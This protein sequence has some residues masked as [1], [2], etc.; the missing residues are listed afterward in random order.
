MWR[1]SFVLVGVFFAASMLV[2]TVPVSAWSAVESFE[3]GWG[4]WVPDADVPGV[5]WHITRSTVRAYQG[6]W[7]LEYYLSGIYDQGT[8]WVE[9][10]IP[11]NPFTASQ[12]HIDFWVYSRVK[13]NTNNWAV[14]AYAG[15]ANPE[16]ATDFTIVGQT[17]IGVGWFNYHLDKTVTTSGTSVIWVAFGYSVRWETIRTDYFDYVTVTRTP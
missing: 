14:V 15:A 8:I 10:S 12:V 11:A 4:G 1:R 9:R 16:L 5:P 13:S 6:I 7:S 17:D 2:A 3:T